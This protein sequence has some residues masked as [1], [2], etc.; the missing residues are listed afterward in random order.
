M[1]SN[2]DLLTLF[3][4][5]KVSII[6]VTHNYVMVL[7]FVLV[8]KHEICSCWMQSVRWTYKLVLYLVAALKACPIYCSS[9]KSW[10]CSVFNHLTESQTPEKRPTSEVMACLQL[11]LLDKFSFRCESS[12]EKCSCCYNHSFCI[13]FIIVKCLHTTTSTLINK[14]TNAF[15]F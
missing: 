5:N 13:Y 7:S 9:V 14:K 11:F 6:K 15:I 3:G 10:R 1:G 2:V 12:I 8:I 4:Q